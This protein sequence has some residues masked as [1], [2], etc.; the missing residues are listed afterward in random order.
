MQ[1]DTS[2]ATGGLFTSDSNCDGAK[3]GPVIDGYK[4]PNAARKW[5]IMGG[6]R[7]AGGVI[8][9]SPF[10]G[11]SLLLWIPSGKRLTNVLRGADD[12]MANL[13][14]DISAVRLSLAKCHVP[15]A[16]FPSSYNPAR[17]EH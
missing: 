1:Q 11:E 14:N 8:R 9:R 15:D 10:S 17:Q 12:Q 5:R 16:K 4:V 7:Y 2:G 3:S 6:E 13:L